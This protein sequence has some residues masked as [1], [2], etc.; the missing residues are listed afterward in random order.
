M[1]QTRDASESPAASNLVSPEIFR[2]P[3]YAY[4]NMCPD[5]NAM[6]PCSNLTPRFP[7]EIRMCL[8][9]C[10]LTDRVELASK[11]DFQ[12]SNRKLANWIKSVWCE[13]RFLIIYQKRKTNSDFI[14]DCCFDIENRILAVIYR[15]PRMLFN[16]RV[17]SRQ[18]WF[19][20]PYINCANV[21]H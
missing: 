17:L 12:V 16:L 2:F 3:P 7:F 8:V 15:F 9:G 21:E 5:G 14:E 13:Y 11:E 1:P 20:K 18:L 19:N 10:V 4:G 6:F